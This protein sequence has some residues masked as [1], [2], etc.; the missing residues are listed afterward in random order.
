MFDVVTFGSA[1]RDIYV[2]SHNL[3]VIDCPEFPGGKA[4]AV[5]AGAKVYID[6]MIFASGGGGTNSAA[7][8]ASQ[9]LKTA[10]CGMVGQD[11]FGD[12]IIKELKK[13]SLFHFK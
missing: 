6:E 9:G 4:M 3:K 2:R 10:Y 7:T 12:L 13:R 11:C 5:G 1:T 8:F